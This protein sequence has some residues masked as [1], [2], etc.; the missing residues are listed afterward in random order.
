[1]LCPFLAGTTE[2]VRMT[3]LS[4][5]SDDELAQ[6]LDAPGAVLKGATLADGRPGPIRFIRE[7]ASGAKVFREAQVHENAFVQSVAAALRDR[8][9]SASKDRD[10]GS[11]DGAGP[12]S[13]ESVLPDPE[14]EAARAV[15]LTEASVALLRGRADEKDVAAYGEWLIRIATQVA[16]ATRSKDGGFF[17]K[18]VT[19]SADEQAFIEKLTAAVG[20]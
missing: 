11:K 8:E 18:R 5:F 2:S 20:R 16:K 6:I 4:D 17:S 13:D 1:M 15:E 7:L 10:P 3:N 12:A 19:V 14:G 9:A